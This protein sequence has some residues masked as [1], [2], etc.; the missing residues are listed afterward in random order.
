[1]LCGFLK[2]EREHL[3]A[4]MDARDEMG[5]IDDADYE[6]DDDEVDVDTY[7]DEEEPEEDDFDDEEI[8]VDVGDEEDDEV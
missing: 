2:D 3:K 7:S 6:N 5:V 8:N 1:M 4:L